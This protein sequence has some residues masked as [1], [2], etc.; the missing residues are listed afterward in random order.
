M[1]ATILLNGIIDKEKARYAASIKDDDLFELYCA[2]NL[3][4]NYDLDNAEIQEGII[5]GSR[6]AGV[7]AAYVLV[8]GLLLTED[9]DFDVVRQPV[10]LEFVIIQAKN[11]DTFKEGPVDKLAASLP[12]LLDPTK[13]AAELEPLFKKEVV[14]VFQSFS[15]G[16]IHA[17]RQVPEGIDTNIL[18]L[19]GE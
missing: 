9:F 14:R 19:Q 17:G 16:S 8:N 3:L 1:A 11:Q 13:Q 4:V 7:D 10:E 5:D 6:D 18:L 2:D 15:C 12:L